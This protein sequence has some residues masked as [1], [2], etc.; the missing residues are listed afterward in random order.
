MA[1][2]Q[3]AN[4]PKHSPTIAMLI[5]TAGRGARLGMGRLTGKRKTAC[6]VKSKPAQSNAPKT[7]AR[8]MRLVKKNF[9]G[10]PAAHPARQ[11][12]T[13]SD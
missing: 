8:S 2:K 6:I 13:A 11:E 5:H 9:D 12:R 7:T 10:N 1:T 3:Q 4:H